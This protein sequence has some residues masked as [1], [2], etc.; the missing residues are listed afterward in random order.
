MQRVPEFRRVAEQFPWMRLESDGVFYL[1]LFK[2]RRNLLGSGPLFGWWST[3]GGE[4]PHDQ[5]EA[6]LGKMKTSPDMFMTLFKP[7]AG[8]VPSVRPRPGTYIH[9]EIMLSDSWPTDIEGWK[10]K[11]E[12]V[13]RLFF[14]EKVSPPPPPTPGQVKDWASWYEWRG[15]SMESPASLLMDY[16]LSVYHL[17]VDV[18]KVIDPAHSAGL[19]GRQELLVHYLGAEIE[20]N[21]LPL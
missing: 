3:R 1:D 15:F 11:D 18:L 9:G 13:P 7:S 20:L 5:N 17:L 12:W 19:R 8:Q 2:A 4:Q 16:P 6:D 10:L 21:F 14:D